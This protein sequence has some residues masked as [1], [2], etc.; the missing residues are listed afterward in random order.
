MSIC[1]VSLQCYNAVW[2][3]LSSFYVSKMEAY[4]EKAAKGMGEKSMPKLSNLNIL[5][6]FVVF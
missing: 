2:Q 5:I 1:L 6:T 3:I 4:S